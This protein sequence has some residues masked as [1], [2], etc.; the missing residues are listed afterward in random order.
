MHFKYLKLDM[1]GEGKGVELLPGL[2]F[3]QLSG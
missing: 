1:G 2:W 3:G